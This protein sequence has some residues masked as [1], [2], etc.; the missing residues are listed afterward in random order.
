MS[1]SQPARTD[2]H[3]LP[4][5]VGKVPAGPSRFVLLAK[6]K[7]RNKAALKNVVARKDKARVKD[8]EN[9]VEEDE[10]MGS[11]FLQYWYFDYPCKT[12][13]AQIKRLTFFQRHVRKANSCAK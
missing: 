8:N 4:P 13:A 2:S 3:H 12:G 5:S 6:A 7:A 10:K 9:P 1:H 11:S